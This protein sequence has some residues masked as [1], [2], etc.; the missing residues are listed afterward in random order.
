MRIIINLLFITLLFLLSNSYAIPLEID[1]VYSF[2][3]V[4]I[5]YQ[6]AGDGDQ[7]LVFVHCWS[8]DK[9]YWQNQLDYFKNN[10][11]VYAIDLAGHGYSG[12]ERAD[13]TMENYAK[14]VIAVFEK[15]DL[16]NV[17]L[18]GH[19]MGGSVVLAATNI[20][21]GKVKALIT[22]D[23]FQDIEV[24]WSDEQY[25]GFIKP[26]EEDFKITTKNFVISIFAEES[27]SNVVMMIS[28]DM[29]SAPPEIALASFKSLFKFEKTALFD[30]L[31]IPVRFINS[32][33]FPTKTESAERHIK[34]FKLRIIEDVGHFPMF[35]KPDEFNKI[36]RETIKEI[37]D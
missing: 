15:E 16:D 5:I 1:T 31:D 17:I 30:E 29:A 19:S 6:K 10:Y 33:R 27:D 18:I 35:E 3:N 8:C 32:S 34:D 25:A 22:I 4:P 24:Q 14:D 11:T 21:K 37:D 2:D 28:D 26:F 7:I 9:S 12:T 23:T 36:L 13:W 20:L